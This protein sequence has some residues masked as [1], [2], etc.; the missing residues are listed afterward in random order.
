MVKVGGDKE[1]DASCA[2]KAKK[3]EAVNEKAG[4]NR[5]RACLSM[6]VTKFQIKEVEIKAVGRSVGVVKKN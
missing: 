5:I 6:S 3:D 1:V 2:K 4:G